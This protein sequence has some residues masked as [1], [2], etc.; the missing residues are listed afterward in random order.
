MTHFRINGRR[1]RFKT[2]CS[3]CSVALILLLG[4][5][6][7][8]DRATAQAPL[9]RLQCTDDIFSSLAQQQRVYRDVLFGLQEAGNEAAGNTRY[10][11][12]GIAWIKT[13]DDTW[14]TSVA[15]YS[16]VTLTDAQIDTLT[17]YPGMNEFAPSVPEPHP[18]IFETRG[19]LTSELLAPLIQARRALECRTAAACELVRQT[20]IQIPD[21]DGYVTVSVRGC[22]DMRM[23]AL[24]SC[25]FQNPAGGSP[26]PGTALDAQSEK[27]I[28]Q[29]CEPARQNLLLREDAVLRLAVTYDASYRSLLQFAGNFDAFLGEFQGDILDPIGDSMSI[30]NHI[31]R[32]PCF[33][34]Q[35]NG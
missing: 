24:A 21:A 22:E 14:R 33:I 12:D 16:T 23:Q 20:R 5:S 13:D 30:L 4:T 9:T 15:A 25:R 10:T 35:C 19:V 18:G 28:E 17:E 3:L 26:N 27:I 1:Q 8:A 6:V 32:L 29:T 31:T 7:P 2:F 11:R 34:S